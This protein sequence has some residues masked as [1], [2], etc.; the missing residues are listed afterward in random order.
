MTSATPDIPRDFSQEISVP[1]DVLKNLIVT[2]LIRKGM[3]EVEADIVAA[4]MT[5]ADL[6][7]I[8]SHGSRT[9]EKYV[10]AIDAGDIDPR[11]MSITSCETPAIAVIEASGG[12]GHVAATRGM[13]LAIL[14]ARE[15]GTGTV[16]IKKGQHYGAAGVYT[17]LAA[18][19]GMIGFS[20]TSTGTATVAAYGSTQP[21]TANNALSWAIPTSGTPF[22]LDTAI[23]ESS[24][25]KIESMGMFGLPILPGW[26]LDAAGNETTDANAAKTLLPMSGARGSALGFVA[27]ALTSA[28]IGRRN[29][30]HKSPNPFGPGS[31]HFFQAIDPSHFGAPDRFIKEIDA[32]IASIKELP[33]AEGVDQVRVAGELEWERSEQWSKAGIPFHCDQVSR[34]AE[35]CTANRCDLPEGW[36]SN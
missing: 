20:T 16:V 26:A 11:A 14:K 5:E 33:P 18:K 2:V 4:R 6:R 8:H 25:G 34:L 36:P 22:V 19:E 31:D 27:S 15:V 23:A 29:P 17:L 32:T 21:G 10:A 30:I 3:F 7:G 12:M 1:V 24:W 13:E 28:L 9:L 35:V